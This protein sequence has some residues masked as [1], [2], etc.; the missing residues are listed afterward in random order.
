MTLVGATKDPQLI[1]KVAGIYLAF[2]IL[3]FRKYQTKNFENFWEGTPILAPKSVVSPKMSSPVL[4][5]TPQF[6]FKI[7][8]YSKNGDV[9]NK[10]E[11]II[12]RIDLDIDVY[13]VPRLESFRSLKLTLLESFRAHT[14]SKPNWRFLW[15]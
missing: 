10:S 5:L 12:L 1:K 4:P 7:L 6:Y 9:G 8:F 14:L 2:C 13:S 15:S 3:T 11:L